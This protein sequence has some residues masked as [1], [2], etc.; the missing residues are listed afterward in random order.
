[1]VTMNSKIRLYTDWSVKPYREAPP[2]F[3]LHPFWQQHHSHEIDFKDKSEFRDMGRFDSIS[4][5]WQK[6]FVYV[7]KPEQA[8][9]AVL[10][11]DWKY[12]VWENATDLAMQFL[13]RMRSKNIMTIVQYNSDD[14]LPII[15]LS[16][17]TLVLRTSFNNSRRQTNEYAMTGFVG[18]PLPVYGDGILSVREKSELPTIGFCG[19]ANR[20][21]AGEE[22]LSIFS[23]L[24]DNSFCGVDL[25]TKYDRI[26]SFR[27]KVLELLDSSEGFHTD[28]TNR[29]GYCA[30]VDRNNDLDGLARVRREYYNSIFG[31]DYVVCVRGKGNYS[32]RFYEA[33]A[34]GRIPIFIN[35]DSPL[36]LPNQIDWRNHCAWV[37]HKDVSD[38]A[39]IV[40]TFHGSLSQ[41]EF[42]QMQISNRLLWE[43]MLVPEQ[44]FFRQLKI[45][46]ERGNK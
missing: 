11:S 43:Q 2:S 7:D 17:Q 39:E 35:T 36:P 38:I 5:N 27:G 42:C 30:G 4:A 9:W 6:Y 23:S 31:S 46:E 16:N 24:V 28:F 41:A 37:E 40:R 25:Q 26:Y 19:W 33:L 20:L 12:Y 29:E 15:G 18:D 21:C 1:V 13:D 8:Q 44:Y 45:I 10:P 14:D 34:S 22:E 3:V 32:Y